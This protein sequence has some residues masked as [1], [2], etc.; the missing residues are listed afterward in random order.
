MRM[1]MR[2]R[3]RRRELP[4]CSV[5]L[6]AAAF[7]LRLAAVARA[8]DVKVQPAPGSGF[9]V[10]D[11]T[12]AAEQFKVLESG[13]VFLGALPSSGAVEDNP[14]CYDATTGR[15]G[16]CPPPAPG[17]PGPTG[18]TG[19]MGAVGPTGPTGAAST[20]PGPTGPMGAVGPTGPTGAA[21]TVPGPT[22]PT[23]PMG[24]VGPTG[25]TGATGA[26]SAAAVF[27]A[28]HPLSS[29][30]PR[31]Y[32]VVGDTSRASDNNSEVP[33]GLSCTFNNLRVHPTAAASFTVTLQVNAINSALACTVSGAADCTSSAPVAVVAG[34][35]VQFSVTGSTPVAFSTFLSCQ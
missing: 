4:L 7:F 35:R 5:A 20:V 14:L 16:D 28:A 15:V 11:D 23:G 26:S 34:D 29:V 9:V 31:F 22:G 19:P 33:M 12:G 1:S 25:P 30:L 6:L 18:P 3:L 24:A 21:S 2:T 27:V 17:I 13:E 8:D 10:T 32:A